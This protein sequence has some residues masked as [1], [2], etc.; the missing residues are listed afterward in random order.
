MERWARA[1]SVLFLAR[2]DEAP[3]GFAQ[4]YPLWSSWYARR[5]W[6]FS[7]LYVAEAARGRGV[8]TRLV[9][10]VKAYALETSAAGILLE[11]PKNEPHLDRF[12]RKH[13]FVPDER[14]DL[15]RYAA[16]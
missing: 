9:E 5:M 3:G 8:A 12:Y 11:L 15:F 4:L 13:G 6:F 1:D 2:L 7:D 16:H 10:S 14:F